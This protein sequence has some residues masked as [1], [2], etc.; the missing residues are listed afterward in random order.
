MKRALLIGLMVLSTTALFGDWGVEFNVVWP[1]VPGV[2][3]YT[4][5]VT[6][7]L[8][9]ADEASGE[10]T[11]GVLIRPGTRDN[12]AA[13]LF[14]EYGINLGYRQYF[15]DKAQVELA[16][17]PSYAIE[18]GN[19]V[20]GLDYRGF[21]L[22]G[23]LYGGYRFDLTNDLDFNWYL[24]P[25]AGVGYTVISDLGPAEEAES[26]FPVLNLQVGGRF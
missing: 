25:Q 9:E 21:A 20:D 26:P 6:H 3:I 7:T 10:I 12:E 2:R 24:M 19:S 15:L 18:V 14:R 1:F 5:K 16:L 8:W 22:T 4:A 11:F 23:E 17:Y 13:D